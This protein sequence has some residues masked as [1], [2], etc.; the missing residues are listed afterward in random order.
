MRHNTKNGRIAIRFS[1]LFMLSLLLIL[2]TASLGATPADA[3][4]SADRPASDHDRAQPPASDARQHQLSEINNAWMD[5]INRTPSPQREGAPPGG[6][7]P[8]E[9]SS[10]VQGFSNPGPAES[11]S[12]FGQEE[13]PSFISVV[14]RFIGLMA[15]MLGVFYYIIRMMKKKSGGLFN[16]GGP[17]QVLSSVPLMQGKFLQVVDLAGRILVLGVSDAGVNLILDVDDATTAD[18]IRLWHANR[19]AISDGAGNLIDR[20][21]GLFKQSDFK[22]WHTKEEKKASLDFEKMLKQETQ[23]E[24]FQDAADHEDALTEMLR[25]QKRKLNTLKAKNPI[26]EE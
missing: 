23:G 10:P 9:G 25:A 5:Q 19:P 12:I 8:T 26:R 15:L 13:G 2:F 7:T 14:L 4:R 22:F 6:E 21:G 1:R 3:P 17:M 18:K 24:L 20:L 16:S 11:P